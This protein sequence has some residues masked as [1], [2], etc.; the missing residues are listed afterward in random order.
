MAPADV[1]SVTTYV[2]VDELD[3]LGAVMAARDRFLG[4]HLAASTLVTVPRLAR[5]VAGGD[6][7]RRCARR[8]GRRAPVSGP[9]MGSGGAAPECRRTR[10]ERTR[11]AVGPSRRARRRGHVRDDG[12]SRAGPDDATALGVGTMR[13]VVGAA[14]LVLVAVASGRRRPGGAR[15]HLPTD[16]EPTPASA[17]R[18]RP[19]RRV[20][21]GAVPAGVLRRHRAQRG[22]GR[23]A[24]RARRRAGVRGHVDDAVVPEFQSRIAMTTKVSE[25]AGSV[26]STGA[27]TTWT[28]RLWR[29]APSRSVIA[30]GRRPSTMSRPA[31]ASKPRP[32]ANGSDTSPPPPRVAF[33]TGATVLDRDLRR[34][35]V[36][37]RRAHEAGDEHVGRRCRRSPSACRAA[38]RAPPYITAIRVDERHRLDLVVGDI[39]DGGLELLV[40]LLD[41]GPHVDAQLGVEVR[42]RLVEQE[43]VG[44]AHQR[45][46]HRDALALAAGELAGLAVEQVLDLQESRRPAFIALSRSGFGTPCISSPKAMFCADVHVRVE[47]VGLEHHRDVALRRMHPG[48][49]RGP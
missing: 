37:R 29:S 38:A 35:Q 18:D 3:S 30:S 34:E 23:H 24:R 4:V 21:G 44:V 5:R 22:G 28:A 15:I 36:H 33:A 10:D 12:D 40:Q 20:R 11:V 27:S 8:W 13:I 42:Q 43:D 49:R 41:L 32:S 17:G 39:D 2:V 45:P 26:T 48:H 46:A 7:H 14:G 1:L 25:P 47:R 16:S 31:C 6:Q 9:A 19:G